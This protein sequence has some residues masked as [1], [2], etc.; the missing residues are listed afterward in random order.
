[1]AAAAKG[2]G[3]SPKPS[4]SK[5]T[6]ATPATS[7][8]SSAA[9]STASTP[10]PSTAALPDPKTDLS[11]YLLKLQSALQPLTRNAAFIPAHGDLAF[12]RSM[13]RKLSNKLDSE[14]D[15]I[16]SSVSQLASWIASDPRA[17]KIPLS[18]Q[19]SSSSNSARKQKQSVNL[20]LDMADVTTTESFASN[21]GE[22]VD[23]L[24]ESADT[25]LDEFTGKL[26]P[27][28]MAS[29][30]D[31]TAATLSGNGDNT[32]SGRMQAMAAVQNGKSLPKTGPL[33]SWVLN[34]PIALPQKQFTTK[35]DNSVD[36][37]WKPNL[38]YGKP[39]AKVPLGHANP[40]RLGA[41]G[42]PLPRG[43]RR[44]MYC[45]EGDPLDNPYY[46]EIMHT[47]PPTHALS[48]PDAHAKDNPPPP[49]NEKDPS[50]STDACPFQW[51]STKQQIEQLRDHL[52][53]D[54]VKEIAIDLEHH[55]YRTYQGIVCLMQLSTRWGDWII[56]TLSD[57]V[58]QH[59]ELLNSSFTHPDKVKVLHGANHDVL[60]LQRDLGLY[61]VNLFDTY[62]ATNVL[63]FPSHG[64]NYLMARYCNF[65]ADKRYQLADWRIRPLP[66]EML[67]YARSDTHTLLYIYD[68]LRHELM[69]SGGVDAIR[70][71]FVRSRDVATATYAK[72]EWDGEGETREGWRSVWRKW[73]GEAAVGTE[74]RQELA[75]MKKEE[76]LVRALHRWRDGVAREEDES[77][78]YVLGANNLMMLAAR[79]PLTREGVLACVPPN[80][81]GLKKRV[82]E[83]VGLIKGEV[84]EWQ[85][86]Q[87]VRREENRQRLSEKLL[88]GE[89]GEDMD[90]GEAVARD[91]PGEGDKQQQDAAVKSEIKN[92]P[93][94]S[95]ISHV[96]A[97]LPQVDASIWSEGN[98]A[99]KS[100]AAAASSSR[101]GGAV[102]SFAS[103]LFGRSNSAAPP[104]TTASA[105]NL[106]LS[107]T[108]SKLFGTP[109]R[110]NGNADSTA[111]IDAIKTG[112][113]GQV[114][115]LFGSSVPS[116]AEDEVDDI[117]VRSVSQTER[118][119]P[120][121]P[122][123]AVT[124][125]QPLT[126]DSQAE[127]MDDDSSASEKEDFI[128][129]SNTKP[130]KTQSNTPSSKKELKKK[131]KVESAGQ[132]DSNSS[133]PAKKRKGKFEGEF[134]F[135]STPDAFQT[136]VVEKKAQQP[137]G[138]DAG[139]GK[140]K[141]EE[142]G[143]K[144]K[145][146]E[147][148]F[149]QPRDRARRKTGMGST[150]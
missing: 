77:P 141:K 56:D 19:A 10:E 124:N 136:P 11:A 61:L 76:R 67:Y 90:V 15:R 70:E 139:G 18:K 17:P 62:H 73:G 74:E 59:A 75:Q 34:A 2:S 14:S 46:H 119:A 140:K 109:A 43:P 64:L 78:R 9:A 5:T 45:A 3:S 117:D 31:D 32:A 95:A 81:T 98:S 39:N 148:V 30:A 131:R 8:S 116:I 51:V 96:A 106:T 84:E 104:T 16:L 55:S 4:N 133:T 128:V 57:D 47:D 82:A 72:E 147:G 89:G 48:K 127:E 111:Q 80:A 26:A 125:I 50:I 58:R 99:S 22:L 105:S 28:K 87:E 92:L 29:A 7:T 102:R 149:R 71:V 21:L 93:S 60:W 114:G 85:K 130:K 150:M 69:E 138:K 110:A 135:A 107:S 53:E 1:M 97:T 115:G 37:L 145:D 6:S 143:K 20:D 24:L 65:D 108:S 44:G 41:D 142:G 146:G 118:S 66:K 137:K 123:N 83:L 144:N 126:A 54:R 49:L 132:T 129:V 23:H 103:N 68:N 63:M 40:P 121:T 33:P 122:S 91:A 113:I 36:T 88:N 86:D 120:S 42:Q 100:T 13:D 94:I 79:A 134:D 101:F 35:A 27:R 112:F 25:C 12:H 38:K 52:D